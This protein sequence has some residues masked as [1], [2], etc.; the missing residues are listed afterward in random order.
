MKDLH[1]GDYVPDEDDDD[2]LSSQVKGNSGISENNPLFQAL[3]VLA[4]LAV[5]A[6]VYMQATAE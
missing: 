6:F 4:F 5:M 1:V 2:Y 3:A